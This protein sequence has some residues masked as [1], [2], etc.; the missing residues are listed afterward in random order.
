[1]P[2]DPVIH[3]LKPGLEPQQAERA[4]PEVDAVSR[5]LYREVEKSMVQIKV[6]D[7]LGSGF[8][9]GKNGDIA[10]DAHVVLGSKH[11]KVVTADGVTHQARMTKLDDINDLAILHIDGMEGKLKPLNLGSSKSLKPDQPVWGFG[12][13]QGWNSLYVEPGYFQRPEKGL[14]VLN[15]EEQPQLLRAQ[16]LLNQMTP[17]EKQDACAELLRPMLRTMVNIQPGSSGGPLLDRGG[18]VCGIAD[19]SD[20]KSESDFTP[21]ES[22][23][24]LMHET[25]PKFKFTYKTIDGQLTLTDITRADGSYRPPFV[26]NIITSED[27]YRTNNRTDGH[28]LK[29]KCAY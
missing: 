3:E 12:H 6:D 15:G 9:V 19:L 25:K 10:T 20:L 13:P 5:K 22:L 16:K 28:S 8:V 26:D 2:Q 23:V 1:M 4:Q 14:D 24:A 7:G 18:N 21:V 27:S 11:I 17:A 29:H